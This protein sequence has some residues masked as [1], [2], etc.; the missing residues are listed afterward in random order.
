MESHWVNAQKDNTRFTFTA[1]EADVAEC[2][3]EH[4]TLV[5]PHAQSAN[6]LPIRLYGV[7]PSF[8]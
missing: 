3:R 6:D 7:V 2:L 1:T 4:N 8:C 5:Q